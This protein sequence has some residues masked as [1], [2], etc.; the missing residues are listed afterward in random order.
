MVIKGK[1]SQDF[2]T[3][4][5]SMHKSG[6]PATRR[7]KRKILSRRHT[8]T[9]ESPLFPKVKRT[10]VWIGRLCTLL[11][12]AHVII[13]LSSIMTPLNLGEQ[14]ASPVMLL[15]WLIVAKNSC[16]RLM[17]ALLP[18]FGRSD[19]MHVKLIKNRV[20]IFGRPRLPLSSRRAA[21]RPYASILPVCNFIGGAS[22]SVTPEIS[23]G[24]QCHNLC[25]YRYSSDENG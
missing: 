11:K 21:S 22:K 25:S 19:G 15:I 16:K 3:I 17:Q 9:N 6:S 2:T 12:A 23:P 10:E 1:E 7:P 13:W 4:T 5:P 8:T 20:D 14:S 18:S 24:C